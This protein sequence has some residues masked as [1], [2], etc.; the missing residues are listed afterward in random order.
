MIERI[1]YI[2]TNPIECITRKLST[3][4]QTRDMRLGIAANV[5]RLVTDA[6][7]APM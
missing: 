4:Q 6:A 3:H 1:A 2:S 5:L 7:H